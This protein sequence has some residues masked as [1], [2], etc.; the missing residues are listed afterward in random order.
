MPAELDTLSPQSLMQSTASSS[1]A[2]AT[3][4]GSPAAELEN[5]RSRTRSRRFRTRDTVGRR[6]REPDLTSYSGR[7]AARLRSLRE[8]RG[9]SV[10]E[11]LSRLKQQKVRISLAAIYHY[12]N[13]RR[14]IPP[15]LYPAL[16]AIFGKSVRTFLPPE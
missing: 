3:I 11:L 7:V 16:A 15:N 12:E 9:W 10:E 4:G 8:E 5:R 1:L 13:G 14:S 6:Q 2:L